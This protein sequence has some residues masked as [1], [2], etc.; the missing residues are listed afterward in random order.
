MSRLTRSL[1][2]SV[3]VLAIIAPQTLGASLPNCPDTTEAVFDYVVV[4]AGAGGG[5]LAA[6]LAENG[7]SGTSTATS[8][9]NRTLL[10]L[11]CSPGCRRWS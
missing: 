10:S 7:F 2:T 9:H 4:G 11:F 6:R 3:A 5:P 1:L 8:T